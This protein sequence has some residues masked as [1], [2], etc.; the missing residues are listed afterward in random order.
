MESKLI[1]LNEL[2]FV[3]DTFGLDY[4]EVCVVGS[5]V[6]ALHGIRVNNDIDIIVC[7]DKRE[8]IA[9]TT[10]TVSLSEN[11]ECVREGWLK[12]LTDDEIIFNPELH[13]IHD[14]IKFCKIEMVVERKKR[15]TKQK[16]KE[17]LELLND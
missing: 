3:L 6:M 9:N 7:K 16:D 1:H 4:A 5:A 8:K 15:S 2:K 13:S 12:P 14:G 10:S 11:I 17:D